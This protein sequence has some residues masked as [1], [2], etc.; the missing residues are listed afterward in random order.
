LGGLVLL[1][2]AQAASAQSHTWTFESLTDEGWGAGFGND[3]SAT[4]PIENIGGSN[5]MRV[6]NT[7]SFQD[8]GHEGG[9]TS[10]TFFLA[11]QAAAAN[12]SGYEFHY[13]WLVDTT[14]VTG[15]TFAQL[16]S[17]VNT[18]SGY[19]AQNFP[20]TGKEAEINGAQ[21]ASGQVLTG[22][23]NVPFTAYGTIPPGESFYRIGLI[24]NT[25]ASALPVH[26][27]NISIRP[28]PEPSAL[29]LVGL[30]ALGA[31]RRRRNA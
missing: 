23:V 30:G 14:Q 3:A 21:L 17:Y 28:V 7:A 2:A 20:A 19:Y 4:F 24:I 8:A 31:L 15:G 1:G 10:S 22:S 27:D 9:N 16:G 13:D 5:R 26:Y 25:D 12:P 18:G 29:A 11:M 6:A